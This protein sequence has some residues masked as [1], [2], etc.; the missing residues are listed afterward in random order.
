MSHP[1]AIAET[2]PDRA[3]FIL[4]GETLTY[5]KLAR[6]STCLAGRLSALGCKRGDTVAIILDNSADFFIG[7]WAAQMSGLYFVPLSQ[8]LAPPERDYILSDSGAKVVLSEDADLP[9][10]LVPD[11]WEDSETAQFERVEGSD[12]LY[13]SG[14]TGRPKGVK[15]PLSGAPLGS[16]PRRLNRARD[17]FGMDADTVFLSPAPLY[18]AAPLRW[19]MTVQRLG[20][21]VIALRRFDARAALEAL[22]T[23]CVTHSQWVPT[24]FSRMLA[25]GADGPLPANPAS[26]ICAIH[27]G[28]PCPP[29]L[30]RRMIDWWGPILHEYYSGTEAVG[31]THIDSQDWLAH[32]G[33]VGRAY[34]STIH[35]LD[36][37]DNPLPPGE[38]GRVFFESRAGH[39]YHN[40]PEKGRSAISRQGY[41]TMGDIGFLDEDGFLTLTDRASF[42]II[43]GG[44][45]IYPAEVEAA[46]LAN[47][48]IVDCAV[49]GVPDA[50]MGQVVQA[51]VELNKKPADEAECAAD[52]GEK[53][54]RQVA[55]NKLPRR[56]AFVDRVPRLETGKVRKR[57]LMETYADPAKR[58]HPARISE[59]S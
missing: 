18:H 52:I 22:E 47:P 27:A 8:R 30:K 17:L 33:S 44:A 34:G 29:E 19:A 10:A 57:D 2:A 49:F 54:S 28:A 26:H 6:R 11:H 3:A 48:D 14:T 41:A 12:M 7:A 20:G 37:Q 21:T 38:T 59:T 25:L 35:I 1:H 9:R 5:G 15:R 43:S 55:V 31:F 56:I 45:N 36:D 13:T 23:H 42:T 40:A 51:I 46:L 32:P 4:D 58:G 50:D 24:M 16:D 53:L 39:A